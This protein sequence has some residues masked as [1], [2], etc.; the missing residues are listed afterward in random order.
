MTPKLMNRIQFLGVLAFLLLLSNASA[1]PKP[2]NIQTTEWSSADGIGKVIAVLFRVFNIF[3]SI[4]MLVDIVLRVQK[5]RPGNG[6]LFFYRTVVFTYAFCYV[7]YLNESPLMKL[8]Y[9][10]KLRGMMTGFVTN[11][12]QMMTDSYFKIGYLMIFPQTPDSALRETLFINAVFAEWIIYMILVLAS[13]MTVAVIKEGDPILHMIHGI[14]FVFVISYSEYFLIHAIYSWNYDWKLTIPKREWQTFS[15][16]MAILTL[17]MMSVDYILIIHYVQNSLT[18]KQERDE[19]VKEKIQYNNDSRRIAESKPLD[20]I[21]KEILQIE[22]ADLNSPSRNPQFSELSSQRMQFSGRSF[23]S[24]YDPYKRER[25]PYRNREA[26]FWSVIRDFNQSYISRE[27]N[28]TEPI[29]RTYNLLWITRWIVY[30]FIIGVLFQERRTISTIIVILQG[31]FFLWTMFAACRRSFLNPIVGL[32]II[33]EELAL[34]GF[35]FC[36]MIFFYDEQSDFTH[37]DNF[38]A[39]FVTVCMFIAW[40]LCLLVECVLPILGILDTTRKDIYRREDYKEP[41]YSLEPVKE[42][43]QLAIK[44]RMYGTKKSGARPQYEDTEQNHDP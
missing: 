22:L 12:Q 41:K 20:Q 7:D 42:I 37:L 27:I 14:R 38:W 16:I 36:I 25:L 31:I 8:N 13:L 9:P 11:F 15:Y 34:F 1:L 29:S 10:L 19:V 23:G 2:D 30:T 24:Q 28:T 5:K 4:M 35:Y 26:L 44:M 39:W 43:D 6:L 40:M 18:G 17:C 32:L 33:V 21:K 3:A